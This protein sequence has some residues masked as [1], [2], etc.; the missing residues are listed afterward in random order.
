MG[1]IW[2]VLGKYAKP[3]GFLSKYATV[4]MTG[5]YQ[6]HGNTLQKG[7]QKHCASQILGENVASVV[8]S[9]SCDPNN[10]QTEL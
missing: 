8:S 4:Q 3:L 1:A 5:W 9:D 6:E 2:Y 10:S 7:H